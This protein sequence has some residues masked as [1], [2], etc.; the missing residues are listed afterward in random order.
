MAEGPQSHRQ[1][2]VLWGQAA[3][4]LGHPLSPRFLLLHRVGT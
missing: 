2:S 3:Q 4:V 1:T